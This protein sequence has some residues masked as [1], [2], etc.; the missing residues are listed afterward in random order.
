MNLPENITGIEDSEQLKLVIDATGAGIWDWQI[1]TGVLTFN[2]CW[3]RI[4]GYAVDELHPT[5]FDSWANSVH[6]EDLIL[7]KEKIEKHWRGEL[8]LYEIE[9]RIKHKKGHSV[10]VLAS[11]KTVEWLDDGQPKRMIGT[12]LDITQRKESEQNLLVA[13]HL[14]NESQKIAQ[15][16]G[17]E[18]DLQTKI[19]FWT[20]ET[21]RIHDTSPDDFNPT[22]D[23]G[24]D[25][26]LPESRKAIS[27]A[28]DQAIT[29]GKNY[30][31]E[32]ET[33]TTKGRKIDVRTTCRIT[34][35]NGETV[36]LTEIFQD[37]TKS[38]RVEEV[39]ILNTES[40]PPRKYASPLCA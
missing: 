14:L 28:L 31:L 27:E 2:E 39:L 22:V 19:L 5:Q 23:A 38:K 34:Q 12:H 20:D 3:A 35:K 26:F 30:D 9:A 6:P 1:Q 13:S 18:L 11:G 33:Y 8:K 36:K 29:N 17:W 25:L 37:I 4:I 21:Y 16:G 24:V 32:L 40:H 15:V 10:W 7:A